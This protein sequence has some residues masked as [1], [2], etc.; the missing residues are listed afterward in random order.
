MLLCNAEDQLAASKEQ[1][2]VLKKKLEEVQKVKDQTK[3]AKEKVEKA[4][5]EAEQQGYDI[6]V[7]ETKEALKAK[8]SGVC[9]TYC[10]QVWNEA[11]NQAGVEASFVL[12]KAESV[13]YPPAIRTSSSSSSKADTPL[14]VANLEKNSP[15]KVPPSF[16][17]P[18]K[19][20]E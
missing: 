7:V 12:R 9:R 13:H 4:R 20:A 11:F 18:P 16:G 3:K 10:F 17:S 6:G 1:I 14:E 5:E 8:V 19:V 2:I 15:K